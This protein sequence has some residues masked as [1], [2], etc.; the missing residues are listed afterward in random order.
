VNVDAARAY[1]RRHEL[2]AF[3]IARGDDIVAEEYGPDY[4][5]DIAHPLYSGTKSFWG[6]TAVAAQDDGILRLDERVAETITSW[7]DDPRKADVTLAQLLTLTSGIGFGGLGN[8]VPTCERALETPLKNPPGTTFTYGGIPL[9][10][11]GA[12]LARKLAARAQTPHDYL[13]ERILEPAGVHVARWR[14][15]KDGT[16]T[17][18]TGAFLTASDWLRYG[19]FLLR[20]GTIGGRT[21]VASSSLATCFVGT[22]INPHY[23]LGF[24]LRPLNDPADIVYASGAGGQALYVIPSEDTVVVHFGKSASYDHRA[25]LRRLFS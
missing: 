22:D 18:P 13:R 4:E 21:I 14:T 23:G 16:R 2:H 15:L 6:V 3:V 11:F 19:M 25:F 1:A 20:G 9:Q 5:P 12:V 8:A 17:F 10:I 7:H 24:W